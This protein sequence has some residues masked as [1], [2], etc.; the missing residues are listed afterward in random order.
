VAQRLQKL[1]IKRVRPLAG[2]FQ[3]WKALDYPLVDAQEVA[4]PVVGH[5][6]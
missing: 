5:F 3:K 2:G 1:G 6:R 4:W